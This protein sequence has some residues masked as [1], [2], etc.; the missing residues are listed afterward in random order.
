MGCS[1]TRTK[2]VT[3]GVV[4]FGEESLQQSGLQVIHYLKWLQETTLDDIES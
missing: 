4:K 3:A 2:T 1:P